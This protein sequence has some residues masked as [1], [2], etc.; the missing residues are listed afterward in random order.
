M[1][2]C[3]QATI[4]V[5]VV[6]GTGIWSLA[7]LGQNGFDNNGQCVGDA[8]SDGR[9]A[10]NELVLSV[11]NSL[12]GCQLVPVTLKF[13]ATVGD[14]PFACGTT[15]TGVGLNRADYNPADMRFYVHDIR[16]INAAGREVSVQLD[17]DTIWQHEN[18]AL[19]DF[20]DRTGGCINGTPQTNT[21]VRGV[22]P[23]GE[24]RGVRFVL[25]V[26]FDM[27]HQQP[28]LA[29]SPLNLTSLWWN[30]Q[31]GYKFVRIDEVD[32]KTRLHLGSTGCQ[33]NEAG[34]AVLSCAR[35][36]RPDV[37]LDGFDPDANVIVADL[38]ALFADSELGTNQMDTKPGCQSEPFDAD[39][40]P[41]LTNAGL[42]FNNGLPDP[43]RQVFFR[44]E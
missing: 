36:N 21:V 4:T 13:A 43:S 1:K 38:G 3:V 39:C 30:W 27:N 41:I 32:N 28:Q 19:L 5:A 11:N 22:V 24:Y 40:E 16:L 33:A 18:T 42:N 9:V 29:P 6:I 23:P 17:T 20:E 25:G 12:T 44:V 8:N 35:P 15:Y 10:I 34:D 26:P 31:A 2:S 37:I 7:A 14:A